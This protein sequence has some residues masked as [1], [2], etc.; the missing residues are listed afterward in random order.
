MALLVATLVVVTSIAGVASAAQ[1]PGTYP[2][3]PYVECPE[4]L[5]PSD[6]DPCSTPDFANRYG[7]INGVSVGI[8][9]SPKAKQWARIP[10]TVMGNNV[11]IG[12]RVKQVGQDTETEYTIDIRTFLVSPKGSD[13]NYGRSPLIPVRTVA[14]GSI[15]VEVTLQ[16][17]QRTDA[18]AY[19]VP[20]YLR[21]VEHRTTGNA[22]ERTRVEPATL[23]ADVDL[24][25][26]SLKVDG[27]R[28]DLQASCGTGLRS[29]LAITSKPLDVFSEPGYS[30][31][32]AFGKPF[33]VFD[34]KKAF[35]GLYGGT[36]EGSVDI[37]SLRGCSTSLGDDLSPLLTSALSGPGNPVTLQ[38]GSFNCVKYTDDNSMALPPRPGASTPQDIGCS[39]NFYETPDDA[40]TNPRVRTVPLPLEF[41]DTAP[42]QVD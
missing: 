8:T 10:L 37:A 12:N 27:V 18:D 20:F 14:F 32:S 29:R 23:S 9:G 16:L 3:L 40:V 13:R 17:Q 30:G 1:Q 36:L 38:V 34:P 6:Y 22:G 5:P 21:S 41:P 28:V 25:V 26:R 15:P 19:P 33:D 31:P 24:Q 42:A 2:G 4:V 35:Y 7:W 11:L 39:Q